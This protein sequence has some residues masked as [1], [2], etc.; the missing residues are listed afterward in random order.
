MLFA[1]TL[2]SIASATTPRWDFEEAYDNSVSWY[3]GYDNESAGLAW[4]ESY[5][6]MALISMFEATGDPV[7]LDRL[8]TH[9][10]A[11]HDA[12]DD[13]R[14]VDDYRGISG[15]CW[16]DWYYQDEPYCYVVHSGMIAYAFAAYGAAVQESRLVDH[17]AP[18][19][20]TYGE[21]A[22]RYI[23][24]AEEVVASHDDQWNDAGYYVFRP[25]ADF[26]TYAGVDVPYNQSNA[27]GRVLVALWRATGDATYLDKVEKLAARFRA[28]LTTSASGGYVWNYWGGTY[29]DP[30]EDIS[31]AAINVSFAAD[32][33][34]IGVEFDGDD[35]FAFSETFV[36]HLYHSDTVIGEYVGGVG[37]VSTYPQFAG[38]WLELAPWRPTVWTASA[39]LYRQLAPAETLTSAWMLYAQAMLAEHAPPY[40]AHFFYPADWDDQGEWR[41]ATA[42]G[43]NILTIPPDWSNGC[44]IPVEVDIDQYVEAAQWDGTHMHDVARWGPTDAPAQRLVAYEPAWPFEY[45]EEGVLFEL[46][47]ASFSGEGVY[48]REPLPLEEPVITSTPPESCTPGESWTYTPI[49]MGDFPVWWSLI[50]GPI[51]L[52]ADPA[53][54]AL[55]W[56]PE[57]CSA[58][59]TLQIE[60]DVGVDVQTWQLE[61]PD[62]SDTGEP[63]EP[64][65]PEDTASPEE[66]AG[67]DDSAATDDAGSSEAETSAPAPDKGGCGCHSAT[68]PAAAVLAA[69]PLLLASAR[70]RRQENPGTSGSMSEASSPDVPGV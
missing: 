31:H 52:R 30:G 13:Q 42:Y 37:G 63:E 48:V 33:A 5:V 2:A 70:R 53:T 69:L 15:A 54:G 21:K 68:P 67:T 35:M 45:W 6:L 11:T 50:E 16:R 62:P 66:P 46:Q 56:T 47:D 23:R 8:G 58:R 7:Y 29:V 12:R 49:A 1:L 14:G 55:S 26:L 43:A 32:C 18:D 57:D 24:Y 39:D 65:E 4:G 64:E 17:H 34:H 10:D 36:H 20:E 27:M 3:L 41:S 38:L 25:D 19:G 51:D 59:F 44:A 9:L 61:G 60:N 28:G 40:C 22:D